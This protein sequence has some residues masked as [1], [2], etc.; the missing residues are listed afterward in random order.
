[1]KRK[2]I[3]FVMVPVLAGLISFQSCKKES[4]P[5]TVHYAFTTPAVV[6][7]GNDS[8]IHLANGVTTVDLSWTSTNQSGDPVK[9]DV[10]FG[11][12]SKPPL[13]VAGST[14]L[15]VTGVPVI[16]GI[17]YYWY[18]KMTDANGKTTTGPTWNFTI[19]DP[20]AIFTGSYNA[21]EPAESYSY[22]VTFAKV[23]ETHIITANYWNSGWNAT[24]TMNLT[25][26]TYVLPLTTF[27]TGAHIWT[28][29]ESGTINQTT[30]EMV[31]TYTIY[32]DGVSVETGT[33]TYTHN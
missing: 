27:A 33:H 9:A 26:N 8:T 16:P 11:T 14:S 20:I 32:E 2:I 4:V 25:T 15:S 10:Y 29:E 28:G 17:T 31:G 12:S 30:G 19:Y 23:D 21:D 24:F 22:T 13:Y 3:F 1:M 6:A 5:F 7:P 18:V